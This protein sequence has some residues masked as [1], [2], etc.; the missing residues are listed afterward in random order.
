[1]INKKTFVIARVQGMKVTDEEL[2]TDLIR[3]AAAS[4]RDTIGQIQYATAGKYDESTVRRRFGSWNKALTAAGL[5]IS[6]EV[7][8]PD[9]RLFE[10]ILVLWQHYGR[11]P[12]KAELA[13]APSLVSEGPY[14]RRFRSWVAALTAF[15]EYANGP[16]VAGCALQTDDATAVLKQTGRDP[17]LRL[18]WKVLQRDRFTCLACGATPALTPGVELHVDHIMAWSKGG[19]T[20]SEN[21]QTLCSKCNLGKS[22]E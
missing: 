10:N 13:K 18:R 12:R 6:N 5:A 11:Q 15:V 20:I 22:N 3:T 1:M 8:I 7:N 9:E 2:L 14:K 19:A 16:D 4:G 17:S 21:L